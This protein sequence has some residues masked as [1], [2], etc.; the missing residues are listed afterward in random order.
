[1]SGQQIGQEL[2]RQ[3]AY[4]VTNKDIANV[5]R[6]EEIRCK[7]GAGGPLQWFGDDGQLLIGMVKDCWYR[8]YRR[9]PFGA[10]AA[11]AFTLI[12]VL[13]PLDLLPDVLPIVGQLDD[14]AVVAACG[15]LIE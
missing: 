12:Y 6:S 11:A 1:M 14:A 7:F 9:I 15:V 13:N 4:K 10:A 5:T 2:V 8:N 3:G